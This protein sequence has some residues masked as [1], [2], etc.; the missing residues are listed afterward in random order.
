MVPKRHLHKCFFLNIF[1][2]TY[3]PNEG[4]ANLNG[5]LLILL[6]HILFKIKSLLFSCVFTVD[7]SSY[8]H[9]RILG[10]HLH[11]S[12]DAKWN[13]SCQSILRDKTIKTQLWF[14]PLADLSKYFAGKHVPHGKPSATQ[15]TYWVCWS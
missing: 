2:D 12:L 7:D 13:A 3:I 5:K 1:N 4:T 6:L 11:I 8:I 9:M 10:E 15:A 14:S